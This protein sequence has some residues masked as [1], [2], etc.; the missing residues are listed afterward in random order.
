MGFVLNLLYN[1]LCLECNAYYKN[2]SHCNSYCSEKLQNK[3]ADFTISTYESRTNTDIEK[4]AGL[5]GSLEPVF[6]SQ[7][8]KPSPMLQ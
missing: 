3:P 6:T 5:F 2:F 1:I 8:Q 4:L 7:P